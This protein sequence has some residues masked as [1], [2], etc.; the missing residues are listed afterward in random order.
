[1]NDRAGLDPGKFRV[2]IDTFYGRGCLAPEPL[3]AF[4]RLEQRV[5]P[6]LRPTAAS[7]KSIRPTHVLD[8]SNFKDRH[9]VMNSMATM[10]LSLGKSYP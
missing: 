4:K 2:P 1:V 9:C 6:P 5:K 7:K 8:L 3:S 10:G